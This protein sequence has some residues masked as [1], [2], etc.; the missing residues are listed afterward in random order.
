MHTHL[1]TGDPASLPRTIHLLTI[2]FLINLL[3]FFIEIGA[4]LYGNSIAL[5][6]DALHN[7]GDSFS[8]FIALLAYHIA[9]RQA[10]EIF[11]FGFKRAET[12]GGF[13]NLLLLL[14]SG[15]YLIYEG[16]EKLITPQVVNGPLIVIIS[17]FA[18]VIDGVTARL[19]HSVSGHNT[20]MKMLFLHN[21]A[22]ALGSVGVIISGLCAYFMGWN[23]IDSVIALLIGLYMII[24]SVLSC[25]KIIRILMNAAPEEPTVDQIKKALFDIKGIS[26]IHHI[27]IW[28]INERDIG[29][30]FH[31]I[32]DN[33]EILDTVQQVLHDKFQIKHSTIQIEKKCVHP[34][35][36]L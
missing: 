33:T 16:I 31:I 13:V 28:Y 6:G 27:H 20:N 9:E 5:I 21:L 2:A 30:D 14:I 36:Q 10:T 29:I 11:S 34:T 22:D 23:K 7:L 17:V 3:L 35:C 4:G 12:I 25:P 8:I 1:H 24:Q 15:C 19:S 26:D 18:L 32:A